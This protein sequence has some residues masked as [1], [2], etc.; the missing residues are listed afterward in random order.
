MSIFVT[1]IVVL[2]YCLDWKEIVFCEPKTKC[3]F[4]IN[5]NQKEYHEWLAWKLTKQNSID[6]VARGYW[7]GEKGSYVLTILNSWIKSGYENI[8]NCTFH[9]IELIDLSNKYKQ[10][11]N[12]RNTD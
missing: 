11:E 9:D 12:Q 10:Y 5:K 1:L 8:K 4:Q 7:L 6:Y 3:I 2:L